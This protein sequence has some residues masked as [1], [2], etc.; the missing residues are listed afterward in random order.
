[1]HGVSPDE[2]PIPK[3]RW[4]SKKKNKKKKEGAGQIRIF[5]PFTYFKG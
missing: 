2:A 4:A 1:M 5:A 3:G